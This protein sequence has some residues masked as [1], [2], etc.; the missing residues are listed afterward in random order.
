MQT[1]LSLRLSDTERME[2]G[3]AIKAAREVRKMTQRQ[4]GEHFGVTK[5]AVA[6]W[7]SGKNVP[8]PRKLN[9]L[10]RLLGLDPYVAIGGDMHVDSAVV[11]LPD[12]TSRGDNVKRSRGPSASE[13]T[14]TA[15][16]APLPPRRDE[17]V[18]DVPVLGTTMGGSRGDFTMNNGDPVDFARRPPIIEKR[19]DVFCL[20]V[21]GESM[22]P[23]RQPGDLVYV[24]PNRQ[25]RN[26][27]F[28]VIELIPD[29]HDD[30]RPAFIK[31]LVKISGN[32]LIV[33]QFQP[34][35]L[36]EFDRR[37]VGRL[38]RV[39]DWSELLGS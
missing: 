29:E 15:Q 9:D 10:V 24:D 5:S 38:L 21:R 19:K 12:D 36:I 6:Q 4:L 30:G 37:M 32:K 39:M 22:V 35:K 11:T 34:A 3:K 2:L 17:M 25:P 20:F 16:Q 26:G 31:K 23:W 8:D 14:R 27:D 18:K 13:P 7:E 33:E 1:R 28:V